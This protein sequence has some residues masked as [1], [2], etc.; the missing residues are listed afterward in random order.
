MKKNNL[1]LIIICGLAVASC[2]SKE[3]IPSYMYPQNFIPSDPRDSDDFISFSEIKEYKNLNVSESC[4]AKADGSWF[5]FIPTQNGRYTFSCTFSPYISNQDGTVS[6]YVDM[7]L[8]SKVSLLDPEAYLINKN[9][10]FTKNGEE[11]N[12]SIS[13]NLLSGTEVFIRVVSLTGDSGSKFDLLISL[14]ENGGDTK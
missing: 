11:L 14:E 2:A 5:E 9:S 6:G 13:E 12:C 7:S 10:V 1:V 4:F 8:H 3:A